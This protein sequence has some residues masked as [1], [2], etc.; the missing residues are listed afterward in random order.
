MAGSEQQTLTVLL[1]LRD[2]M[3]SA[4][5]QPIAGLTTLGDALKNLTIGFTGAATAVGASLV[6]MTRQFMATADQLVKMSAITG[7]STEELQKLGYVAELNSSSLEEMGN[8]LRFLSRNAYMASQGSEEAAAAFEKLGVNIFDSKGQLK[9]ATQLLYDVSDGLAK[10]ESSSAKTALAMQLLGRNG[11]TML[12]TLSE[13]SAKLKEMGELAAQTGAIISN[14]TVQAFDAMGDKLHALTQVGKSFLAD[15]LVASEPLII[16]LADAFFMAAH[17]VVSF[18]EPITE[19]V[20]ISRNVFK[21]I[22]DQIDA[23]LVQPLIA[24]KEA[25]SGD[26][27]TAMDRINKAIEKQKGLGETLEETWKGITSGFNEARMGVQLTHDR[28]TKMQ[29]ALH[30]IFA[31]IDKDAAKKPKIIDPDSIQEQSNA[32]ET[33]ERQLGKV[34]RTLELTGDKQRYYKELIDVTNRALEEKIREAGMDGTITQKER[35]QVES[36]SAAVRVYKVALDELTNAKSEA[37]M[38]SED[39]IKANEAAIKSQQEYADNFRKTYADLQDAVENSPIQLS[40]EQ[41]QELSD[42]ALRTGQSVREMFRKIEENAA[43]NPILGMQMAIHDLVKT[44]PDFR[45]A[46]RGLFTDMTAAFSTAIGSMISGS[47]KLKDTLK[48]L[49]NSIKMSFLKMVSDMAAQ[50]LMRSI[51]GGIPMFGGGGGGARGA[52]PAGGSP[53]AGLPTMGAGLAA[54][55]FLPSGGGGGGVGGEV[56]GTPAGGGFPSPL[57]GIGAFVGAGIGAK[58][59]ETGNVGQAG[60]GFGI[61]GASI[62]ALVGGPIGAV[63]GGAVG[64]F[65]GLFGGNR[66][67]REAKK[68]DEEADQEAEEARQRMEEQRRQ[69]AKVLK[70]AIMTQLGGGTAIPEAVD[71]ASKIL[72]GDVTPSDLE[73]MDTGSILGRAGEVAALAGVQSI[74]VGAPVINV[75]VGQ[76]ASSYDVAQLA[77]DLGFQLVSSLQTAAQGT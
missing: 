32:L 3:S 34:E 57:L 73:G 77:S 1:Q 10:T 25:L 36:L 53:M 62:G 70:T 22:G 14:D 31:E 76:V 29:D 66:A 30:K 46:F 33:L 6:A 71:A 4:L 7:A 44:L 9:G 75:S 59:I 47:M 27:F 72:S 49:F 55:I 48:S 12:P 16:A 50:Q 64:L 40:I 51:V 58:G 69:A 21:T 19:L 41:M 37:Q 39:E 18:M 35:D 5:K 24:A 61:S 42:E 54:P 68:A 17:A 60:I 23:Y 11:A 63:I 13:G 15:F 26:V 67:K 43:A 20:V 2:Q 28:L 56:G 65:G 45:S 52:A 8:A 74:N 38:Q